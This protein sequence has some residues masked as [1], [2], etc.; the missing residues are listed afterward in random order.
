MNSEA[1]RIGRSE[2]AIL[3]EDDKRRDGGSDPARVSLALRWL[4]TG[5][6]FR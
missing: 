1:G 3:Y 5:F 2:I 4:G 6:S